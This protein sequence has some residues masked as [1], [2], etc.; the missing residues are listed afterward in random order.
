MKKIIISLL[1]VQAFG[2]PL[3]SQSTS[4]DQILTLEDAID[5]AIVNNKQL[6]IQRQ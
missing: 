2:F 6:K 1:L 3:Y 5:L 4:E